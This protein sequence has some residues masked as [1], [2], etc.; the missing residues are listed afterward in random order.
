MDRGLEQ[1][2]ILVDNIDQLESKTLQV[3]LKI[4]CARGL[5]SKNID[6]LVCRYKWIDDKAEEYQTEVNTAKTTN[7]DF[8][9]TKEHDLYV[10]SYV[11]NNIWESSLVIGVYGKMSQDNLNQLMKGAPKEKAKAI[12]NN[13]TSVKND[14]RNLKGEQ[15]PS[16]NKSKVQLTS[17]GRPIEGF[18]IS[19]KNEVNNSKED[20][21]D[22]ARREIEM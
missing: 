12:V 19:S 17:C 9:Y 5:P 7:P 2:L 11:L 22:K 18:E 10:S 1:N 13:G 14:T 16:I 6:E 15:L 8:N 20:L 3:T 21:S 4:H